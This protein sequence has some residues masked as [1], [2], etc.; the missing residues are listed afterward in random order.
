MA[1]LDELKWVEGFTRSSYGVRY[2]VRVSDP[3]LIP[4]LMMRLPPGSKPSNPAGVDC[5]FSLILGGRQGQIRNYNLCYWNHTRIARSHD[6]NDVLDA[7]ESFVR[8]TVAGLN[9]AKVF[10]HAGV[11][12]WRGRGS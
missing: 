10:V 5:V 9:R 4:E 1:R 12:G 11:V 2:G 6:L 7:F 8:I 3:S